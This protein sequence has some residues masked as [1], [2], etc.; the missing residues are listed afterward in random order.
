MIRLVLLTLLF[1]ASLLT[2][3]R[4]P[5]YHLWLL[6]ILVT[7]FGWMFIAITLL[8]LTLGY[9]NEKYNYPATVTG[10]VALLFF[11]SPIVRAYKVAVKVNTC[12]ETAFGKGS[13]NLSL[14]KNI[15][16]FSFFRMI[17]GGIGAKRIVPDVLTYDDEYGLK[18][19]YYPSQVA[20]RRGCVVVIH[21]GSW[22]SGNSTEL[23]EINSYLA[24]AGYNIAALNYR[25]APQHQYQ[26]PVQDVHSAINYLRKHADGLHIDTGNFVLLGRSAGGQIALLAAY[27]LREPGLK[28]VIAYYAP[29][30]MVWGYS[31]PS[32]PWIMDSRRVMRD[33]LG[34]SYSEIPDN[35]SASS[36]ILHVNKTS[37]PTL[38]IHGENDVLVAYEHSRRLNIKLQQNGVEHY[39]LT[40]PWAVHGC[41]YTLNGPGGQLATYTVERFLNQIIGN[42]TIAKKS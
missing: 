11:C 35:Y 13:S 23:P 42:H 29:A 33:Y 6:S 24:K 25:L 5:Q 31:V 20:G 16:P 2:V 30:D 9:S 4:A 15:A 19:D 10:V 21:G 27:T 26:S 36:P 28:G 12:F 38:L 22:S 18:L 39:L 40:L 8:I 37:V 34:G 41:D 3:L 1:L 7:E 17:S 14:K 32:S